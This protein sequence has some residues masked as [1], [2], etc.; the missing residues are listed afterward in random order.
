[1]GETIF[2]DMD[3]EIHHYMSQSVGDLTLCVVGQM[4]H[5]EVHSR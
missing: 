1:M 2:I 3:P 5:V 4:S